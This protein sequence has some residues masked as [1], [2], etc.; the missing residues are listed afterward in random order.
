MDHQLLAQQLRKPSGEYADKVAESMNENN[1]FMTLNSVDLLDIQDGEKILEIGPG[2]GKYAEFVIKKANAVTYLG[3]DY[4]TDMVKIASELNADF[5]ESGQVQFKEGLAELLPAEDQ[6]IDKIFSVN[7]VYF[8][9]EPGI[10][11]REMKRVLKPGGIC[12]ITFAAKSSMQNLPFVQ[13]GFTMYEAEELAAIIKESG[14][15]IEKIVSH[16]EEIRQVEDISVQREIIF[17]LAK[18]PVA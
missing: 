18:N 1:K 11:F 13:Y 2:N 3:I 5:I 17:I 10:C 8:M 16:K 14:L 12:C 9:D 4:S 15:Q 7:T 6:S